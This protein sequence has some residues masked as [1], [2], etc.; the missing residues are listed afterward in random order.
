MSLRLIDFNLV[1]TQCYNEALLTDWLVQQTPADRFFEEQ[2][3]IFEKEITKYQNTSVK[4][5]K[6]LCC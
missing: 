1:K 5:I 3:I 6:V 2:D 4:Y